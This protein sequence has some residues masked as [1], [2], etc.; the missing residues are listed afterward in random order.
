MTPPAADYRRTM[1]ADRLDR[2][3]NDVADMKVLVAEMSVHAE[4]TR[5]AVD[6]I[7]ENCRVNSCA[8]PSAPAPAPAP[9]PSAPP[10][11]FASLPARVQSWLLLG[12]VSGIAAL[13]ATVVTR[14]SAAPPP[15]GFIE[16]LNKIAA[17]L[18]PLLPIK[19]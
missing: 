7:E 4:Y 6:R 16:N 10:S 19:P 3:V 18:L 13:V 17:L 5:K 2:V 1:D 11:L 15:P 9:A 8:T 14:A 12:G